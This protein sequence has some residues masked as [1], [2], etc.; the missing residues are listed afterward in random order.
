MWSSWDAYCHVVAP[1][2]DSF[3]AEMVRQARERQEAK[4]AAKRKR[5]AGSRY[6][7][8]RHFTS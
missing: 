5:A 4:E 3:Q 7:P 1:Q 8:H 2:G 6:R